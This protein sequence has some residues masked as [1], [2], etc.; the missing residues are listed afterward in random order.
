MFRSKSIALMTIAALLFGFVGIAMAADEGAPAASEAGQPQPQ[1]ADT[2]ATDPSMSGV[3]DARRKT[4]SVAF[5]DVNYEDT[6][7]AGKL[8]LAGKGDAGAQI[9]LFFDN[10]LLGEAAIGE[11]GTWKFES[12]RKMGPG[13]HVFRADRIDGGIIIGRASITVARMDQKK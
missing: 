1:S 4:P 13:Q 10:D 5:T 6:G 11:D 9:Q 2:P 12:D 8:T 3:N 7:D